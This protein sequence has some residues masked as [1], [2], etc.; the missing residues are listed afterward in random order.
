MMPYTATV[1]DI[2]TFNR[3]IRQARELMRLSQQQTLLYLLEDDILFLILANNTIMFAKYLFKKGLKLVYRSEPIEHPPREHFS[4]SIN[5]MTP[6]DC[7]FWCRLKPPQLQEIYSCLRFPYTLGIQGRYVKSEWVFV[8]L[9]KPHVKIGRIPP[10]CAASAPGGYIQ[11]EI[12]N[13]ERF[14]S[15]AK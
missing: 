10:G 11:Q 9:N 15:S 13:S 1:N 5:L 7:K 6:A 3:R 14:N 8:V 4:L 2:R 12:L